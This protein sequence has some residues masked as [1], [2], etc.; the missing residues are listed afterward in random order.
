MS[1]G[2]LYCKADFEALPMDSIEPTMEGKCDNHCSH[3]FV[4]Q[5]QSET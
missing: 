3:N 1:D 5:A 2:K 4:C